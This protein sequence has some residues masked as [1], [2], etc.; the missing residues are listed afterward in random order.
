MGTFFDS[1]EVIPTLDE[2]LVSAGLS[3]M[4][5]DLKDQLNIQGTITPLAFQHKI[6]D[7]VSAPHAILFTG[8]LPGLEGDKEALKNWQPTHMFTCKNNSCREYTKAE[9][10]YLKNLFFKQN[11]S[12]QYKLSL[13]T[14]THKQHVKLPVRAFYKTILYTFKEK[15]G[16]KFKVDGGTLFHAIAHIDKIC[17]QGQ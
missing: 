6:P 9:Q 16:K 14:L 2:S 5:E 4:S 3:K 11:G 7:S 10:I 12:K 1:T 8:I 15:D 13:E 17:R